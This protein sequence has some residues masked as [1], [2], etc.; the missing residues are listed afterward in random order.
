MST[1]SEALSLSQPLHEIAIRT[2]IVF[3]TL[4]MLIRVI[5]KRNAGTISPN[6][7]LILVVIGTIG[8]TSITAGSHAVGDLLLMIALVLLWGYLLDF[9]E[10]RIPIFRRLMRHEQ[11]ELIKDGRMLKR[12]MRHEMITE[13]EL[14]SVLRLS[15]VDDVSKVRLAVMEAEGDISVIKRTE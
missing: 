12:N 14:L 7:M 3:L 2:S 1:F 9:L 8:A 15:G 11:T 5:P 4:V 10:H 13:E 6:D